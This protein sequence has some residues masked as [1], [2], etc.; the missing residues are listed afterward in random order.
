MTTLAVPVTQ[1]VPRIGAVP[2]LSVPV[3]IVLHLAPG[4]LMTAGFVALAPVVETIGLPPIAA[5][6]AAIAVVLVPVE[7]GILARASAREGVSFGELIP[8]RRPIAA[9][10]WAWLV[11]ALILL[12]F[13]GFGLHQAIEPAL[14]ERFFGWLPSWFVKPIDVE[15]IARYSALAWT[16]TLVG[17]FALNGF[18]GPI[19]EELYF[20]G[21]LLPRMARFGRWAA[22]INVSLF[23]LYHLWSPW[24]LVA[25]VLGLAPTVYAVERARNV[26]LGM[27]VHCTL[28]TIGVTLVALMVAGR[29]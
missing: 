2:Q 18:I 24:Q 26:Y 1:P 11:P 29:L 12:G 6:L 3:L 10:R 16:V 8:F 4:I 19:A 5:L 17:Y 21:F 28:N 14:I 7:L 23:S 9:R 25:R 15:G 22:L 20:R 27:V 13:L